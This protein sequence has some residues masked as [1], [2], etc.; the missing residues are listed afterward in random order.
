MG[1]RILTDYTIIPNDTLLS[2]YLGANIVLYMTIL[3]S[4]AKLAKQ[5]EFIK[6]TGWILKVLIKSQVAYYIIPYET[7]INVNLLIRDDEMQAFMSNV[8][9]NE[10]YVKL[11]TAKKYSNGYFLNFEVENVNESE[12]VAKFLS[13]YIKG[14]MDIKHK[15]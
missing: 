7:G 15:R 2:R 4:A 1:R 8:N 13:E 12:R 6:G 14:R 10:L 9:M 5:W 11:I 3:Q